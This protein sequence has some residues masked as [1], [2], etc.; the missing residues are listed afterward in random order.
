LKRQSDLSGRSRRRS[1]KRYHKYSFFNLQYSFPASPGWVSVK[2]IESGFARKFG[3]HLADISYT[4]F[5]FGVFGCTPAISKFFFHLDLFHN[6]GLTIFPII[7]KN[8]INRV[9]K[10]VAN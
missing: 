8:I 6:G 4:S 5:A 9:S 2:H 1:L 7:L 3:H 10:T